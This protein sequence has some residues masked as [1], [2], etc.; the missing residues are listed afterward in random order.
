MSSPH[1]RELTEPIGSYERGRAQK[2]EWHALS[3]PLKRL[4][5]PGELRCEKKDRP[6]ECGSYEQVDLPGKIRFQLDYA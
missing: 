6:R 3:A 4:L 2:S 1:S 5:E